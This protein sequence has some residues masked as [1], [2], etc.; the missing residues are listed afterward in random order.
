MKY[1]EID[2]SGS[3]DSNCIFCNL[4]TPKTLKENLLEKKELADLIAQVKN[5]KAEVRI[6][7]KNLTHEQSQCPVDLQI[8]QVNCLK[9]KESCFVAKDGIV[10]PCRGMDLPIGNIRKEPLKKIINNSEVLDNLKDHESKIKGP[11]RRCKDFQNCYGC[12]ARTFSKTKDYLASDPLCPHNQNF[13]GEITSL[14][15][16]VKD[17]IPQKDPM[18]VVTTLLEVG[19]RHCK[20]ESELTD[21]CPFAK[22]DGTLEEVVYME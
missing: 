21:Q 16:K 15:F 8:S 3:C 2:T 9:H 11:C 14:P 10:Y 19:E 22:K 13:I 5:L 1:I 20:V 12:R 18:R 4:T 7:S 17:L 6:L